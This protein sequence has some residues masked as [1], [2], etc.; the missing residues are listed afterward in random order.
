[1][2]THAPLRLHA[3]SSLEPA[4]VPRRTPVGTT[5]AE[6]TLIFALVFAPP[7][8]AGNQQY[9]PLAA[10]VRAGLAASIA[11]QPA[12]RHG[13]SNGVDAAEWLTEMS[14]RLDRRLPDYRTRLDLLRTVHYEATR[15]GLDPQLVLSVIQVESNFR[16]YAVS[17]AGARGY[18]QVMPFWVGLIGHKGDNLF[19]L[20]TNLRFGCVILKHYLDIENGNVTRALARY[21]GSLGKPEYPN[22]VYR[23]MRTAWQ[24]EMKPRAEIVAGAVEAVPVSASGDLPSTAPRR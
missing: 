1:M 18:M 15:A 13:F 11:D 6:A 9:E 2:T 19:N 17:S 4:G 3:H 5:L 24:Y 14:R 7:C 23:A 8:F 22:M 10:N 21:N 16:K 20:R 12:P